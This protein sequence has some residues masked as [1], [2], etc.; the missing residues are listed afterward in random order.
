MTR[1]TDRGELWAL[2]AG[3]GVHFTCLSCGELCHENDARTLPNGRTVCAECAKE[4]AILTDK[5]A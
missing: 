5:D 1:E 3:E 2:A 4:N